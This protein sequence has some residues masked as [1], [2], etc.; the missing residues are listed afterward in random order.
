MHFKRKENLG[1]SAQEFS[2]NYPIAYIAKTTQH[3]VKELPEYIP[4]TSKFP[5]KPPPKTP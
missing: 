2:S 3:L 5:P 1:Q 4:K